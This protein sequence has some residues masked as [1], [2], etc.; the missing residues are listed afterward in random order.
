MAFN[1]ETGEGF[2][3]IEIR[4]LETCDLI[5]NRGQS[6]VARETMKRLE[7][8]LISLIDNEKIV[9]GRFGDWPKIDVVGQGNHFVDNEDNPMFF[10]KQKWA[11][12]GNPE[13]E[14]SWQNN[15]IRKNE[16]SQMKSVYQA[17]NSVLS[18]LKFYGSVSKLLSSDVVKDIFA[19]YN[20]SEIKIVEPLAAIINRSIRIKYMIYPHVKG[21]NVNISMGYKVETAMRGDCNKLSNFLF[22]NGI[23]SGDLDVDQFLVDV[24]ARVLYITDIEFFAKNQLGEGGDT[25]VSDLVL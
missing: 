3:N 11:H 22:S 20:F 15:A 6:S 16:N 12:R 14:T 4:H 13:F 10:V 5:L 19:D 23:W 9:D 24:K 21:E 25:R 2:Q 1:S 18:E 7:T 17:G 8:D